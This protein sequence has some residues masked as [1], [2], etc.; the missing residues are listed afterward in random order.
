MIL[1]CFGFQYS[2]QFGLFCEIVGLDYSIG[3]YFRLVFVLVLGF[4]VCGWVE[5]VVLEVGVFFVG[6]GLFVQWRG[7]EN[8]L[9]GIYY[10]IIEL[11]GLVRD[12]GDIVVLGQ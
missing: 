7:S 10:R 9:V 12:V 8:S 4:F 6:L 1:V 3:F 2:C 11:C 5:C